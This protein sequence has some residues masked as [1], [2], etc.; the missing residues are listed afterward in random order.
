MKLETTYPHSGIAEH[1]KR[2]LDTR[3]EL[4]ACCDKLVH[5]KYD[6]WMSKEFVL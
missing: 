4:S 2:F 3:R 5:S 6:L 1:E